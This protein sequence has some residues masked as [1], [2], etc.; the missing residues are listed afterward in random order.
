[1][2]V[3]TA[4]PVNII[5]NLALSSLYAG[6]PIGM[7]TAIYALFFDSTIAG[8]SQISK[9]VV[10]TVILLPV[11]CFICGIILI[12]PVLSMLR[13][14]GLGGPAFVY[15]ICFLIACSFFELSVQGGLYVMGVAMA[16]S[17]VFCSRAYSWLDNP[18]SGV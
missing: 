11:M 13:Y 1:M 4:K 14:F 12:A 6:L 7:A 8:F 10:E 18:A 16:C 9:G 2:E 3:F 5:G 17:Y 15:G